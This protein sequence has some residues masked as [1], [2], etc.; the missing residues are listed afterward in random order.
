MTSD[1]RYESRLTA[2]AAVHCDM[3]LTDRDDLPQA[4][5][6]TRA[7]LEGQL[8]GLDPERV[9]DVLLVLDE[10]ASNAL[11]HGA[12]RRRIGLTVDETHALLEV[13]D[14]SPRPAIPDG[15]LGLQLV[16]SVSA[17]WGQQVRDGRKTVWA[18]VALS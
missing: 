18:R 14:E 3:G 5:Q 12:G 6:W 10:L 7:V 11:I 16:K 1:D 17:R 8:P 13:T 15:G 9:C 4:H 2:Q